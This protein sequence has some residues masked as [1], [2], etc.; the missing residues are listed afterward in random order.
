MYKDLG[1]GNHTC[2]PPRT[3]VAFYFLNTSTPLLYVGMFGDQIILYICILCKIRHL[4]MYVRNSLEIIVT[5]SVGGVVDQH[6][7]HLRMA[8]SA[9]NRCTFRR[10]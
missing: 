9:D 6:Y 5:Y 1:F 3:T 4:A 10:M 8:M 2:I 7:A